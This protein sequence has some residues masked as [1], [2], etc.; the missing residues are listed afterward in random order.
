ME[1]KPSPEA[2][3]GRLTQSAVNRQEGQERCHSSRCLP[4][5]AQPRH[6]KRSPEA[7]LAGRSTCGDDLGMH[8]GFAVA[9]EEACHLGEESH[10]AGKGHDDFTGGAG[11]PLIDRRA[12]AELGTIA[13]GPVAQQ[14]RAA[15]S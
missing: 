14:V 11:I 9:R 1:R 6:L 3:Q 2:P 8:P 7:P 10:V 15:D 4:S 13:T 5:E 12:A